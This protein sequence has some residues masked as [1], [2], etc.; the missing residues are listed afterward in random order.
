M[1]NLKVKGVKTLS[2][3]KQKLIKAGRLPRVAC[4]VRCWDPVY[5]YCRCP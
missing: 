2:K 1:E 5:W 3:T 4:D